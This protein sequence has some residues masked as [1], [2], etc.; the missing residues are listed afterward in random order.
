MHAAPRPVESRD[1][2]ESG[3]IRRLRTR[4]ARIAAAGLTCFVVGAIVSSFVL[5]AGSGAAARA[6]GAVIVVLLAAGVAGLLGVGVTSLALRL[7]GDRSVWESAAGGNSPGDG[8]GHARVDQL[9]FRF[10]FI[11]LV[12]AGVLSVPAQVDSVTYLA[13]WA[14]QATFVPQSHILHCGKLGCYTYTTGIIEPVGTQATE[15]A[16]VPLGKPT[17]VAVAVWAFG[18]GFDRVEDVGDAIPAVLLSLGLECAGGYGII[19]LLSRLHA[20]RRR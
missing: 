16:N 2:S 13:G 4:S 17:R 19:I 18:L 12:L 20:A 5:P 11:V 8:S 14:P 15:K 3:R 6:S 10:F 7:R 9:L 1:L